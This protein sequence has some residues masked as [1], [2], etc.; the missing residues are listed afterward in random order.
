[1]NNSNRPNG[2][3]NYFTVNCTPTSSTMAIIYRTKTN[4]SCSGSGTIDDVNITSN[5]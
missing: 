1:M 5:A 4:P 3:T 2:A